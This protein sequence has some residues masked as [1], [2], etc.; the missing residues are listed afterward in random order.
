M[1]LTIHFCSKD[2]KSSEHSADAA[3]QSHPL[4]P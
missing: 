2:E 4:N 1:P 3:P